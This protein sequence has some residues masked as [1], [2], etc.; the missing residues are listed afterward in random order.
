MVQHEELT[1]AGPAGKLAVV[2]EKGDD[3]GALAGSDY[4]GVVCHPHPLYGGTMDN[5][6]VTTVARLYRALG[7]P[8]ARFNFRGV[9]GS[10]G[11]HDHG[12]GERDD[13]LAVAGRIK[14][15]TGK[16]GLL[17]T[18]Y[19]FGSVVV[20]GAS[21]D[22]GACHM[23]LIAPPVQRYSFAPDNAFSCPVVIVLG[24]A[25]DLVDAALTAEWARQLDSPAELVEIAGA[26]HFFH[27][28]LG[29]LQQRLGQLLRQALC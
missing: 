19:S 14:D 9:A 5:K 27:G 23:T 1:I 13:L 17:V 8:V 29:V 6:V 24:M 20:A 18:G 16:T 7:V 11:E 10:E 25:D 12:D 3:N 4:C 26:S 2:L 15:V 28:Q 21:A 22:L